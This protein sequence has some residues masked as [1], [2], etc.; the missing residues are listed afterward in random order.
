[1][2][3]ENFF[4]TLCA[5]VVHKRCTKNRKMNGAPHFADRVS[6]RYSGGA[7]F[8]NAQEPQPSKDVK[9]DLKK[10]HRS[11]PYSSPAI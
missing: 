1:M 8:A 7:S 5:F 10:I 6:Q 11:F 9:E 4:V 3:K 2:V